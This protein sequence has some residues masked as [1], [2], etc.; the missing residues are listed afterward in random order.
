MGDEEIKFNPFKDTDDPVLIPRVSETPLDSFNSSLDSFDTTFT[1]PLFEL[2]S[3]YTLNYDNSI[4]DIQNEDSDASET[5]T[6]M[7][8]IPSGESKVHIEVLS[9]LWGNRLPIPD[10]S[11]PLSRYKGFKTEQKQRLSVKI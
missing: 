3:E 8:E 4:F 9:L 2:D 1:N 6:L 10:G 11:L 5:E 7:D